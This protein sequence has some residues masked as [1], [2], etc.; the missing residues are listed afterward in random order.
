MYV[1]PKAQKCDFL[2]TGNGTAGYQEHPGQP[3]GGAL[4][5]PGQVDICETLAIMKNHHIAPLH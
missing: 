5:L 4:A 1:A 3:G 2:L